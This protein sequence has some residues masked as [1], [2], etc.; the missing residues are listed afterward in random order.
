MSL[1]SSKPGS[2]TAWKGPY[3]NNADDL[4]DPWGHDYVFLIPSQHGNADFDIVCYGA[5]G[6]Q[7]G[8]DDNADIISGKKSK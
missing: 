6:Q 1:A 5:D 7:G 2:S 4:K 8:E 3:V